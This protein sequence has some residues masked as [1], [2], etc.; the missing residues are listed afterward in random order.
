M[1]ADELK[2]LNDKLEG[3]QTKLN[4][5]DEAVKAAAPGA[6]LETIQKGLADLTAAVAALTA[7]DNAAAEAAKEADVKDVVD[8]G[9][10]NEDQMA[11]EKLSEGIRLFAKD[12]R[13]L[14]TLIAKRL[15]AG[16]PA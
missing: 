5:M 12:L 8:A 14:R 15:E 10:M 9:L 16:V 6:T 3:F 2:K 11:T 7:K 4:E 13:A 1:S